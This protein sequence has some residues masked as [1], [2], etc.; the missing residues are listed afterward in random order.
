MFWNR[1]KKNQEN[2]ESEQAVIVSFDISSDEYRSTAEQI[3]AFTDKLTPAL[4]EIGAEYDGDEY[5]DNECN[6]YFYGPDAE[7]M[8]TVIS[9][10][11]TKLSF[12]PIR[13]KLQFGDVVNDA[14]T[15]EE[16]RRLV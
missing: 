13:F 4:Q 9:K 14:S 10:A 15:K 5:G 3:A 11:V 6:L 12:R 1:T 8:Y 16:E 7:K 2:T